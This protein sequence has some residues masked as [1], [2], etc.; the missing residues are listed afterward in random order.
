MD[1]KILQRITSLLK[2]KWFHGPITK[3]EAVKILQG[4]KYGTFLVRFSSTEPGCFAISVTRKDK[5][6]THFR[7]S[8]KPKEKYGLGMC[9]SLTFSLIFTHSHSHSHSHSFSFSFSSEQIFLDFKYILI[10]FLF[11]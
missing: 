4:Q 2:E 8:H 6:V 5:Q 10:S 3:E 7:V 9:I 1:N 11:V